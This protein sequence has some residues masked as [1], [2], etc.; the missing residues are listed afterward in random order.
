MWGMTVPRKALSEPASWC[1][2]ERNSARTEAKFG[3]ATSAFCRAAGFTYVSC[4]PFR[5]PVARLAAGRLAISEKLAG[6]NSA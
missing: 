1:C 3:A 6:N 5:V 4:S 2:S